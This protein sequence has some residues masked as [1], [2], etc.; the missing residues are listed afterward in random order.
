MADNLPNAQIAL[1]TDIRDSLQQCLEK[2]DEFVQE[3]IDL[4]FES[5]QDQ[6][7]KLMILPKTTNL[8]AIQQFKQTNQLSEKQKKHAEKCLTIHREKFE[9]SNVYQGKQAVSQIKE[10]L[11]LSVKSAIHDHLAS[12]EDAEYNAMNFIDDPKWDYDDTT[13]AID[14]IKMLANHFSTTLIHADYKL[15]AAIFKFHQLKRLAKS[16]YQHF[17]HSAGL[18]TMIA[19]K[20]HD[21]YPHI[22]LLV[23]IILSMEWASSTVQRGFSQS[24]SI[25]CSPTQD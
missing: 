3:D 21:Q 17:S 13:Y 22:L 6:D 18:W 9:I 12:L 25:A 8:P 10:T 5:A 15:D 2:L 24:Q 23:E 11:L 14:D 16:C 4:P 1:K 7:G 20:H 19:S